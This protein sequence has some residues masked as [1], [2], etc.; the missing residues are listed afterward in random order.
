MKKPWCEFEDFDAR[1]QEFPVVRVRCEPH[2]RFGV[3]PG[4]DDF[5]FN[6]TS[7]GGFQSGA[8]RLGRDKVGSHQAN[9]FDRS[10]DGGEEC[11]VHHLRFVVGTAWDNLHDDVPRRFQGAKVVIP[12]QRLSAGKGPI[13]GK[14]SLQV[15]NTGAGKFQMQI[16]PSADIP[17]AQVFLTNVRSTHEADRPVDDED[18][19][20][21][22]EVEGPASGEKIHGNVASDQDPALSK[23]PE[24]IRRDRPTSHRVVQEAN[25]NASAGGGDHGSEK[26][27]ADLIGPKDVI[28][29]MNVML[30]RFNRAELFVEVGVHVA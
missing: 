5:N 26:S 19:A 21:I 4:N 29:Q 24:E 2:E 18:L 30:C 9:A 7:G 3:G 13:L 28:L 1:V 23:S 22:A 6:A 17:S 10:G 20:V 11:L 15:D 12:L 8:K 16:K 14:D 27:L 25:L